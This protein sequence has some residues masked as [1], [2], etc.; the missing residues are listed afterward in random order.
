MTT[1]RP[2]LT[3]WQ[4]T[5]FPKFCNGPTQA[6]L[7]YTLDPAGRFLI[8]TIFPSSDG[9]AQGRR[10]IWCGVAEHG[11]QGTPAPT[12]FATVHFTGRVKGAD[13]T[14]LYA[15]GVCL[16]LVTGTLTFGAI[17]DCASPH[18]AEISGTTKL[19]AAQM[20]GTAQE[21]N[22]APHPSCVT[23][24]EAYLGG[25]VQLGTAA[26]ASAFQVSVV[27]L[28]ASSWAAGERMVNCFIARL[29]TA[30]HLAPITGS[31][32]AAAKTR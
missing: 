28:P 27:P 19:S 29:D 16:P 20:P 24:T 25:K 5:I 17:V 9:W 1:R 22:T 18:I 26:A 3:E 4:N 30:G 14:Y 7:G 10:T 12:G 23:V 6:Y 11:P 15:T 2:S 21:W 32:A 31:L 8:T 13:Q